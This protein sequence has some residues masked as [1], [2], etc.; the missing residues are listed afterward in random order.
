MPVADTSDF[1]LEIDK[2]DLISETDTSNLILETDTSNLISETDTYGLTLESDTSGWN[3][4]EQ[5]TDR[6]EP[7]IWNHDQHWTTKTVLKGR[8]ERGGGNYAWSN[9]G[10]TAPVI[11]HEQSG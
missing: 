6:S 4:M 3:S 10:M 11:N 5:V 9:L 1:I 7:T 2:P 8:K